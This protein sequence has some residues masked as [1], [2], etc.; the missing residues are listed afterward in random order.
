MPRSRS[1][2]VLPRSRIKI[3]NGA[4]CYSFVNTSSSSGSKYKCNRHKDA[5]GTCSSRTLQTDGN[6]RIEHHPRWQELKRDAWYGRLPILLQ[7]RFFARQER[8][9][10]DTLIK[11][12]LETLETSAPGWWADISQGSGRNLLIIFDG[13]DEVPS[14]NVRSDLLRQVRNLSKQLSSAQF[15]LTTRP[16]ILSD[17]SLHEF[18]RVSLSDLTQSSKP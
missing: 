4:I 12:E 6:N 13:L 3:K 8:P 7:L 18:K 10:L 17:T 15:I 9:S 16:G 5:H 11:R 1:M 2:A 14:G